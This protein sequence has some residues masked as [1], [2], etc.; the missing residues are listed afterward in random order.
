MKNNIHRSGLPAAVDFLYLKFCNYSE[1]HSQNRLCEAF[2]LLMWLLRPINFQNI[3]HSCKH[4]AQYFE[5]LHG[6][7]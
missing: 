7:E 3:A 5:N 4:D 1:P 2:L 6:S